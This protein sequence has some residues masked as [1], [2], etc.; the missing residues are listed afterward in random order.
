MLT[1]SRRQGH[2]LFVLRP[3]ST[4][5]RLLPLDVPVDVLRDTAARRKTGVDHRLYIESQRIMSVMLLHM[6]RKT[7]TVALL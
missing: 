1:P 6:P 4:Q 7:F 5:M 3:T 2:F